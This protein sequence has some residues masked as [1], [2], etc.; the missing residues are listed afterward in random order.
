M[1]ERQSE[2]AFM[3]GLQAVTRGEYLEALAYFEASMQLGQRGSAGAPPMKYLSYYGLCLAMASERVREAQEI[4]ENAVRAEFY[5]PELYLNLGK[6]YLK[7]GRRRPAFGA[8]VRGL[9]LNPRHAGLIREL[10]RLGLR[11]RPVLGFLDR[12]NPL[13]RLLG[14]ARASLST[15]PFGS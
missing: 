8:F 1:Q 3:K 15:R 10:R 14:R 4:C 6:V 12:R 9:R 5:N 13:N 2:S 11:L 7:A